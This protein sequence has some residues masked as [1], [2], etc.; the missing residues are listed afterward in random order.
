MALIFVNSTAAFLVLR[1]QMRKSRLPWGEFLRSSTRWVLLLPAFVLIMVGEALVVSETNNRIAAVV[2]PPLWLRTQ[3]SGI[4]DLVGHPFSAPFVLIVVAAVTEEFLF[5]GL[6]LRGLLAKTSPRRAVLFSATLFAVM[7]LNPWQ[8]TGAFLLGLIFGW[9][10]L[11]TRSL[12]LC[13]V[14]HGFHNAMSLLASGLPFTV[15]G[16]N[17]PHDPNIVLFQPWWFNL[18]GVAA[19]AAG[20]YSFNRRSP[21]LAWPSSLPAA[22]PPLLPAAPEVSEP[23]NKA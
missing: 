15:S 1:G 2:P 18:I 19:L 13:V 9:V 17:Q 11:R 4:G 22:L 21:V 16:F 14:G 6:I 5:R 8:M 20:A 7:H 12:A 23:L 3:F 10:Y